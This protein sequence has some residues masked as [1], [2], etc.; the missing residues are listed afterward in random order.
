MCSFDACR[1]FPAS[2]KRAERPRRARLDSAVLCGAVLKSEGTG[3]LWNE[4]DMEVGKSMQRTPVGKIQPGSFFYWKCRGG[5]AGHGNFLL[6]LF[7]LAL[8]SA[9]LLF[10]SL[11][12]LGEMIKGWTRDRAFSGAQKLQLAL[13]LGQLKHQ[14]TTAK[15]KQQN[16]IY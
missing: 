5:G 13:G 11:W 2:G 8:F 3:W 16:P 14:E 9:L 12:F 10:S 1:G 7:S 15:R 6:F 4:S